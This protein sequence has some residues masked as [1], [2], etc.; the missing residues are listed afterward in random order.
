MCELNLEFDSSSFQAVNVPHRVRDVLDILVQLGK[1]DVK[2]IIIP[3]S[4]ENSIGFFP[5]KTNV[6][7]HSVM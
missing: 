5:N 4:C 3:D 6:F 1:S 2:G 7:H